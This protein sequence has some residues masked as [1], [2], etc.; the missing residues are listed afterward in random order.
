[1]SIQRQ[2]PDVHWIWKGGISFVYEVHPRIVVK[3]PK[4]GE[5]EGEQF[6]KELKIYKIFSQHTSF[7]SV[8][9]CF[10]YADNGIFLEYM[11]DQ[12]NAIVTQVDML[13]PLPLRKK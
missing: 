6:R 8:V 5:F 9:Q 12:Q 7:P 2:F 1:M 4:P 3:V 13:E 11:R 10:Y